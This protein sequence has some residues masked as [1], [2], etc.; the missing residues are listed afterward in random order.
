[1]QTEHK[2]WVDRL[3]PGQPPA[4]PA[5]LMLEEA[6]ELVQALSKSAQERVYGKESRY[7]TVDWDEKLRDA[8]GDCAIA[9]CSLCNANDWNYAELA[10]SYVTQ[11]LDDPMYTVADIV[12]AAVYQVLD[13]HDK[14]NVSMF[15]GWLRC[16][17]STLELDFEEC[18]R[19]TWERVKQ[20]TR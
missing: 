7:R 18:V 2:E 14:P 19:T 1:M 5:A 10:G 11:T 8:V 12:Q 3:F 20:R 13:P 6:G 9:A 17:C 16:L 15:L 4:L